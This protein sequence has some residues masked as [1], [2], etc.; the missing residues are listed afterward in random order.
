MLKKVKKDINKLLKQCKTEKEKDQ[1]LMLVI[2]Y[3]L[4]IIVIALAAL[5]I[6]A[7]ISFGL[8]IFIA[9]TFLI[10]YFGYTLV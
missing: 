4:F 2:I 9:N 8:F 10:K 5:T 1:A 6:L 7:I 3:I